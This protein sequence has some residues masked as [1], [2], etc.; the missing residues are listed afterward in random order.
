[1]L[2][3]PFNRARQKGD[4]NASHAQQA[5]AG[6]PGADDFIALAGQCQ[7]SDDTD[8]ADAEAPARRS[9]MSEAEQLREQKNAI[10]RRRENAHGCGED[11]EKDSERT[12]LRVPSIVLQKAWKR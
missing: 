10:E 3:A 5:Q 9:L 4:E 6:H 8:S 1:M 11:D 7:Q 2:P 12:H